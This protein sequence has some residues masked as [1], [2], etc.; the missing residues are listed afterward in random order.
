MRWQSAVAQLLG[1]GFLDM[2]QGILSLPFFL[3]SFLCKHWEPTPPQRGVKSLMSTLAVTPN[4]ASACSATSP[5]SVAIN[6][7]L[8]NRNGLN[9]NCTPTNKPELWHENQSRRSLTSS[10]RKCQNRASQG[11]APTLPLSPSTGVWGTKTRCS[12]PQSR[13][14]PSFKEDPQELYAAWAAER[15]QSPMGSETSTSRVTFPA[16]V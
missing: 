1:F 13:F 3:L 16:S 15:G 8:R 12:S 4:S 6:L 10:H 5:T 2:R 14:C 7:C 11:S 9:F